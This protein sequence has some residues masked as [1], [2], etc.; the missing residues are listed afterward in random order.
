MSAES[1]IKQEKQQFLLMVREWEWVLRICMDAYFS[2]FWKM[3]L[4]KD[5]GFLS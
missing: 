3:N 1:E 2:L 4:L 5:W